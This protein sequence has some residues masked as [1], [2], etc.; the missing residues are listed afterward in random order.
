MGAAEIKGL[1][2]SCHILCSWKSLPSH[3]DRQPTMA[4]GTLPAIGSGSCRGGVGGQNSPAYRVA[5]VEAC[6]YLRCREVG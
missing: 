2:A 4:M 6:G 1:L 3:R 5:I